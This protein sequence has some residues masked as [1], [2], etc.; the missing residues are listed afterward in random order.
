MK[1]YIALLSG[2]RDSSAMVEILLKNNKQVDYILF[3]DT[4]LE[5]DLMYKYLD[6]FNNYLK[7]KYNKKITF[8]KPKSTFSHWVFGK[9]T[10]GDRKGWIRGL[11][12]LKDPC[13]WKRESKIKTTDNFVKENNI[14]EPVFYVG[15]TYSEMNRSKTKADNQIFPLI[16]NRICEADVD[17]ILKKIDMINPLYEFFERTGCAI[18][19]Y[20]SDRSFYTL[21]IKFPEQWAKMKWFESELKE[22]E[23]QGCNVVN[24][25][26]DDRRTIL[27]MENIFLLNRKHF[28]TIPPRSCE[29]KTIILDVQQ[30]IEFEK[31]L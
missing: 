23:K 7:S 13:F 28:S 16:E 10:R 31:V 9:V 18:C 21:M 15:Y 12:M 22:L 20:Q 30:R 11:P 17:R 8:L 4:L 6:K 25:Q 3:D 24:S 29:C 26:W 27:E 1:T 2:G 5:F 14:L 19:P